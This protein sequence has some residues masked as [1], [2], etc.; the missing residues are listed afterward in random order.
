M[1]VWGKVLVYANIPLSEQ[2]YIIFMYFRVSKT[3]EPS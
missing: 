2:V 1:K 3:A